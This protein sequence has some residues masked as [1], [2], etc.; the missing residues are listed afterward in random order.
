M[1]ATVCVMEAELGMLPFVALFA[2]WLSEEDAMS[3]MQIMHSAARKQHHC[4]S[5]TCKYVEA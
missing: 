2:L 3:W 1:M 5:S 4:P